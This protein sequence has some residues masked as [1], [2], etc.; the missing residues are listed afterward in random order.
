MSNVRFAITT[1]DNP[2]NPFTE[3]DKWLEFDNDKSYGT[4]S[5]LGRISRTSDSLTDA[6]NDAEI[7]RAIDQIIEFD[8]RNIYKKVKS[9]D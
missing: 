3:F 6:E 8:F 5:L 4:L 9:S 1:I 7:E 2:F